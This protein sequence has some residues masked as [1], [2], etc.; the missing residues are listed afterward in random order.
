MSAGESFPCIVSDPPWKFGDKLPGPGRGAAKHY[1]TLSVEELKALEPNRAQLLSAP[2]AVLF[3]WRVSSMQDEA[4]ELVRDWGFKVKSELVWQKTTRTVEHATRKQ[5]IALFERS[6][7]KRERRAL[8]RAIH[9]LSEPRT[10]H[11][12]MGR[13]VRMSHEVCLI[14]VRGRVKLAG[15][16]MRS[17]FRAPVGQH[18]QKP[19]RFYEIVE[20]LHPGPYLE[21]FAR[22]AR[23]GW[24]CVGNEVPG[25]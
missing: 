24:T 8:E 16:S 11:F 13:Y 19:D 7:D 9:L 20:A 3:L 10:D 23:P 12:G 14:C 5:L 1:D 21:Q 6:T 18:S 22:R 15:A 2:D 17:T 25:G 4:L